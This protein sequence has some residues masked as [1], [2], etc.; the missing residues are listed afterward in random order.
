MY[1]RNLLRFGCVPFLWCL[2]TTLWHCL[3]TRWPL[4]FFS[5]LSLLSHSFPSSSPSSLSFLFSSL[6]FPPLVITRPPLSHNTTLGSSVTFTCVAL[7]DTLVL[8][9]TINGSSALA[10]KYGVV[11][12]NHD[13]LTFTTVLTVIAS[14]EL[15]GSVVSCL[16]WSNQGNANLSSLLLIQGK[17]KGSYTDWY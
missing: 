6:S 11:N 4:Y 13:T 17:G 14:N 12:S 2:L 1:C 10:H 16:A 8:G 3:Y 9:W 7:P 5:S 15:N